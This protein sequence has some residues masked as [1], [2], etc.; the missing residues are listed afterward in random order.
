MALL[1]CLILVFSLSACTKNKNEESTGDTIQILVS[2]TVQ[3]DD[4]T[5]ME[6]ESIEID[7]EQAPETMKE[8]DGQDETAGSGN[9]GA[10]GETGNFNGL[11]VE[12]EI[13]I[14]INEGEKSVGG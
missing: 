4:T 8:N 7:T 10:E 2:D 14:E 6:S 12:D 3:E 11:D 13:D 5:A 1:L 9:S